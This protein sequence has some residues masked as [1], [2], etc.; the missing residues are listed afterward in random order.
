MRTLLLVLLALTLV[1]APASAAKTRRILMVGDSWCFFMW[2]F[3]TMDDALERAGLGQYTELAE[4]TAIATSTAEEWAT[5]HAG[6]LDILASVLQRNPTIDI[7]HLSIGGND[8]NGMWS[9]LMTPEEEQAMQDTVSAW[10]R[11]VI[12]FILAQRP[13]IRVALCSYEYMWASEQHDPP[14]P[15]DYTPQQLNAA[16]IR[17]LQRGINSLGDMGSRVTLI[18]NYGICQ[19]KLGDPT[20]N[21]PYGPGDVP[22]PGGPPDYNPFPGGDPDRLTPIA[23]MLDPNAEGVHLNQLGYSI[24]ADN[25][26]QQVYRKWLLEG[27]HELDVTRPNGGEAWPAG[28]VQTITWDTPGTNVGGSVRLALHD[29]F[30][31]VR[32][33]DMYADNTGE[34]QW[35]IPGDVAPGDN[36]RVRVQSYA[37]RSLRDFSEPFSVLPAE[38]APLRV[39]TPDGGESWMVGTAHAVTWQT[40]GEAAGEHVRIGIQRGD[41]FLGWL[42]KRTPNDG[43]QNILLPA[44]LSPGVDYRIRLQAYADPAVRDLSNR[45]FAVVAPPLRITAPNE[46]GVFPRGSVLPVTWESRPELVG[47]SV[48]IGIHR[49]SAFLGW[50]ALHTENDGVFRAVIPSSAVPGG[51][52]RIR[53]QSYAEPSLRDFSDRPFSVVD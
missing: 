29:G 40:Q 5:N 17:A 8:A 53:V 22:C 13:T 1:V 10:V 48:R 20:A 11:T 16:G 36:Y 49:G 43:A 14:R 25:C 23:A 46:G 33:I 24:L 12:E 37:Y 44:N 15:G 50:V 45:P 7:V 26:I 32:W 51:D 4:G 6:K 41:G 52:Y 3:R 38:A 35:L 2:M 30:T 9:P 31:F 27:V 18:N 42:V 28:S 47:D 34:Y 19:C 21:P 39:T